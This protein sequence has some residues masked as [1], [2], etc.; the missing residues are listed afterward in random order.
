MLIV[1]RRRKKMRAIDG[2]VVAHEALRVLL[3]ERETAA[4]LFACI[5]LDV[6]GKIILC[7]HA[8]LPH[9]REVV[10]SAFASC[11]ACIVLGESGRDKAIGVFLPTVLR[12]D[13]G[14][15]V[16]RDGTV[17]NL[18]GRHGKIGFGGIVGSC[19]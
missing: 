12:A 4:V 7:R 5:A 17:A 13:R 3:A 18:K 10:I 6:C 19:G 15:A 9:Q 2:S 11:L 1:S 16:E 8:P 14:V